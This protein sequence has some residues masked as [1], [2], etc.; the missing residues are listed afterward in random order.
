M[1]YDYS[2][3]SLEK[4]FGQ[5]KEDNVLVQMNIDLNFFKPLIYA[6]HRQQC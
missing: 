5:N 2:L 1:S 4:F 6:K 3:K